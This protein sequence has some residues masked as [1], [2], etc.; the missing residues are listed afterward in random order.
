MF[1]AKQTQNSDG[2]F[3]Y[4]LKKNDLERLTLK[5][6]GIDGS[7]ITVCGRNRMSV[8]QPHLVDDNGVVYPYDRYQIVGF[9]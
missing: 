8:S 2:Y 5:L 3:N 6:R 1:F 4:I 7:Q 9:D